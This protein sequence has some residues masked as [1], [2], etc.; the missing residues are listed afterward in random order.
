M[1]AHLVRRYVTETDTE[2]DP[3]KKFEFDPQFGFAERKERGWSAASSSASFTAALFICLF[4]LIETG[5]DLLAA[6]LVCQVL[7]Y[8]SFAVMC[9]LAY[10]LTGFVSLS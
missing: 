8:V 6:S 7:A 9:W 2:P 3:A 10:Q 4:L 1:G 5:I